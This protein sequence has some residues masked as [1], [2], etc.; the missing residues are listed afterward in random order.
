MA[1]LPIEHREL[2]WSSIWDLP[3]DPDMLKEHDIDA[4]YGNVV[5]TKLEEG[6][7]YVF[8]INPTG[9]VFIEVVPDM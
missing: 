5:Y 8:K 2:F 6:L 4:I 3:N 1:A 7:I 9:Q